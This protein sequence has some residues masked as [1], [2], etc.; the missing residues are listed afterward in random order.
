MSALHRMKPIPD[1]NPTT[2][3][4]SKSASGDAEVEGQQNQVSGSSLR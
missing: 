2:D 3:Q 4:T 1:A